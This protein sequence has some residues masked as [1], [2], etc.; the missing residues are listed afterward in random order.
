MK[1]LKKDEKKGP[2]GP[3]F[4]LSHTFSLKFKHHLELLYRHR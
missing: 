3:F 4:S 1:R 2:I